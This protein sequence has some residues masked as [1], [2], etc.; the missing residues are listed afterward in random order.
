[1][2]VK[3][4]LVLATPGPCRI[5]RLA[6]EFP[7]VRLAVGADPAPPD[8]NDVAVTIDA[9]R[10]TSGDWRAC[11]ASMTVFEQRRGELE[12]LCAAGEAPAVALQVLTRY[13]RY[14]ARRNAASAAPEL[15][16]LLARH[17]AAFAL[18]RPL[19][20][21]DYDHALDTWQWL[22]RLRPS[23]SLAAQLAAL[24]HDV[25][26]LAAESDERVEHLAAD[27]AAFKL[28][29]AR[30]GAEIAAGMLTELGVGREVVARVAA[31]VAGHDA[32]GAA[33]G[34]D[35]ELA[36]LEDADALSFFSLAS[37]GF[38]DYHGQAHAQ[39]KIGWALG[40]MSPAARARLAEVSLRRDVAWLVSRAS[41]ERRIS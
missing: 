19:V 38:V 13:Q 36:A 31:L 28:R 41:S 15:D 9:R 29:H 21:A 14:V 2:I 8:G 35:A 11:D 17:R 40:R 3:T 18:D 22:L 24:F 39:R 34:G 23:A 1:M 7:T 27:Y 10:W 32:P 30:A 5:D 12:L 33:H 6:N 4:R 20:R 25:E 16:A 37:P 26:R